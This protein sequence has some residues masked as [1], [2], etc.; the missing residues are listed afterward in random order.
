MVGILD[1]ILFLCQN[2]HGLPIFLHMGH[3]ID[4]YISVKQATIDYQFQLSGVHI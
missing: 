3:H 1:T 2:P 4:W